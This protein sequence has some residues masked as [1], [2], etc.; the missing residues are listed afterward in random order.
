[1][2][3][4]NVELSA[5]DKVLIKDLNLITLKDIIYVCN[6]KEDEIG[7][8]NPHVEK[9]KKYVQNEDKVIE[10]CGKIESEISLLET[11]EEQLEF[12]EAV[13]IGE[14]GLSTLIRKTYHML[15]LRTFFTAGEREVRA[16]TFKDGMSA[17]RGGW[18]YTHRLPAGIH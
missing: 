2:P 17:P 12:M 5:E 10:I 4:R 11:E 6:V 15:G 18:N 16:R 1:M 13:G 8:N 3:A 14:S 9:I 7:Q